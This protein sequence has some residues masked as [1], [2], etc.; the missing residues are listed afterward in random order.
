MSAPLRRSSRLQGASAPRTP[1]T[2][3][4]LVPGAAIAPLSARR[5]KRSAA[6]A[7]GAPAP[8]KRGASAAI[9]PELTADLLDDSAPAGS[10]SLYA[11]LCRAAAASL[12]LPADNGGDAG[13]SSADC[14]AAN[15]T[16][17]T[18]TPPPPPTTTTPSHHH[19]SFPPSRRPSVLPQDAYS[20][21]RP[22]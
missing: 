15:A 22:V 14:I 19:H 10:L 5:S 2:A 21:T 11:Q 7:I 13:G 6:P 16:T 1:A 4:A 18:P 17:T 3:A 12:F 8:G 9:D 20:R